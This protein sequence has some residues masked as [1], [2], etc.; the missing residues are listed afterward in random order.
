MKLR[1]IPTCPAYYASDTGKIF[2][3]KSGSL[4]ELNPWPDNTGYLRVNP[5]VNGKHFRARVHTLVLLAFGLFPEHGQ[6][7]RHLNGNKLDNSLANLRWG[8]MQE[9]S[10]DMIMHGTSTKGSKSPMTT[11]TEADVVQLRKDRASGMTLKELTKKFG[12]AKSTV[13]YI[14][15][16]RTWVHV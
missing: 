10:N 9:N 7:V 15:N 6:V 4:M 16:R 8:T 12:L 3:T 5:R 11:L 2:S 13:S 1:P 14:V